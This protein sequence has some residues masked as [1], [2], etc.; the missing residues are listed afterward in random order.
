MLQFTAFR[1]ITYWLPSPAIEPVSMALLPVR[2]QT[3]LC[4]LRRQ[5]VTGRTA[6]QLQCL[7]HLALGKQVEKGR[8]L[9]LYRE[10]LLQRVVKYR[11]AGLVV[12]IGENN[13]V[14]VGQAGRG[15]ARAEVQRSANGCSDEHQCSEEQE[16]SNSFLWG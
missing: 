4:D 8:L 12:E 3:S 2:W 9:K 10:S 6:H 13:G 15:L 7:I 14:F 1:P 16:S 5:P 11:V